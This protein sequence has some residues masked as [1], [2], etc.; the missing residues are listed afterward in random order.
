MSRIPLAMLVAGVLGSGMLVPLSAV[1]QP[2]SQVR[3][4]LT[5]AI[6]TELAVAMGVASTLIPSEVSSPASVAGP[7]CNVSVEEANRTRSCTAVK[8]TADLV[9]T[10]GDAIVAGAGE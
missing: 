7:V 3:I 1:A 4:T 8:S 6:R 10:V 2:S 5:P 9:N